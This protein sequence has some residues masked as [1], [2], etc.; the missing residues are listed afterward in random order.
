MDPTPTLSWHKKARIFLPDSGPLGRDDAQSGPLAKLGAV[1][2]TARSQGMITTQTGGTT[3]QPRAVIRSAQS[4]ARSFTV[5]A[6]LF[7]INTDARVAALGALSHSLPLYALSEALS[8]GADALLAPTNGPKQLGAALKHFQPSHLWLTPQQIRL[9]EGSFDT[10][11]HVIIG[12]GMLRTS[13]QTRLP[14][15]FPNA[16]LHFFYGTAETSF[17][18]LGRIRPGAP[19]PASQVGDLYPGVRLALRP[20][21]VD[22]DAFDPKG[23]A[24]LAQMAPQP[25]PQLAPQTAPQSGPT[26]GDPPQSGQIW[27]QSPYLCASRHPQDVT[28]LQGGIML[29]ERASF[30]PQGQ[31]CVLGRTD[32][33]IQIGDQLVLLDLIETEIR[34]RS[35]DQ[36]IALFTQPIRGQDRVMAA[37]V[38][39]EPEWAALFA[40]YRAAWHP[41]RRIQLQKLPRLASGKI[42][43]LALKALK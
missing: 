42:D 26:T 9:L 1:F 18:A 28:W 6:G 10:V 25:D 15:I 3:G 41:Q 7:E 2:A 16:R 22:W 30:T 38:G 36:E 5:N 29:N 21:G 11:A 33:A 8:L 43:Y 32:R 19:L 4:W 40:P 17:I 35:K 34:S 14:E 39:N 13:L 31:L 27:V 37:F 24:R 23:S 20:D 12:G